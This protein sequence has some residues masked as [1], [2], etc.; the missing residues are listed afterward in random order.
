MFRS[1]CLHAGLICVSLWFILDVPAG[2]AQFVPRSTAANKITTVGNVGN[3][4]VAY[5]NSY[6]GL[7]ASR[8]G[9]GSASSGNY[10]GMSA[11]VLPGLGG[12]RGRYSSPFPPLFVGS[13]FIADRSANRFS[14][15]YI[16]PEPTGAHL[17]TPVGGSL[18]VTPSP[19]NA[20]MFHRML[21]THQLGNTTPARH[22]QWGLRIRDA[23]SQQSLDN[24]PNV[25]SA[26]GKSPQRRSYSATLADL[27]AAQQKQAISDGW[28]L[29]SKGEYRQAIRRFE[30]A[31]SAGHRDPEAPVGII[32]S[33]I[34]DGGIQLAYVVLLRAIERGQG[35]FDLELDL[36]SKHP[37]PEQL[38]VVISA[39]S[40]AARQNP[41]NVNSVA[42]SAFLLWFSGERKAA[43]RIAERIHKDHR[44]SPFASMAAQ[45]RGESVVQQS[46][47]IIGNT[48]KLSPFSPQHGKR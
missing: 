29:F 45:M 36:R 39:I 20:V 4:R 44:T 2:Y 41:D 13:T 34:A 22:P 47:V 16:A 35:V 1:V 12:T 9:G 6:L 48:A 43:L 11:G 24:A 42:M 14:R 21:L 32:F 7:G 23:L 5:N 25:D 18:A 37:D 33:T 28:E 31:E 15:A 19:R 10:A 17:I 38:S 8:F 3:T 30:A 40:R 27:I 26:L 46:E